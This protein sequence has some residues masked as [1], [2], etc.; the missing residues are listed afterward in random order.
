M[1]SY[2]LTLKNSE[3]YRILK[4]IL[5]AFDGASI[6][7]VRQKKTHIEKCLD[8]AKKGEVT[9]P[10]SSTDSLMNDLLS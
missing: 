2:T 7:P 10:F 4:K 9:G 3:D 1:A 5:K 6:V 8:E